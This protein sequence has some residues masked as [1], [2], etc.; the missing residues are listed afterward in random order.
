MGFNSSRPLATHEGGYLA[1]SLLVVDLQLL[2]G[3]IPHEVGR[4]LQVLIPCV[5]GAAVVAHQLQVSC[6]SVETVPVQRVLL[7]LLV[8]VPA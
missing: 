6:D 4:L 5:V 3:L 2:G 8:L 7:M 1:E